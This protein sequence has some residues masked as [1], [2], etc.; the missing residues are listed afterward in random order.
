[1]LVIEGVAAFV[2]EVVTIDAA[3]SEALEIAREGLVP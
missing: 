1:M 2:D 3:F